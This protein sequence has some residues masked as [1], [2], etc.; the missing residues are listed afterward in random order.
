[1][2]YNDWNQ[3]TIQHIIICDLVKHRMVGLNARILSESSSVIGLK[4]QHK[5]DHDKLPVKNYIHLNLKVKADLMLN[6]TLHVV[7]EKKNAL[8]LCK[9]SSL[10]SVWV[11][12]VLQDPQPQD[13]YDN[14]TD[15]QSKVAA[16]RLSATLCRRHVY[17]TSVSLCTWIV[18]PHMPSLSFVMTAASN[19]WNFFCF[20]CRHQ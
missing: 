14:F 6:K 8:K 16:L 19:Q 12:H 18:I 5:H 20:H 2:L 15:F 4:Q 1:M 3:L 10:F 11:G 13:S 7:A 9:H 17:L